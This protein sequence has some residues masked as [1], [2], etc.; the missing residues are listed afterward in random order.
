MFDSTRFSLRFAFRFA[1]RVSMV[2]ALVFCSGFINGAV[3]ADDAAEEQIRVLIID[4]QNNHND[5]PKI[6]A[7]LKQ[8]LEDNGK[9]TVD[10]ERTRFTFKGDK[11]LKEF[12]LDDGKEYKSGKRAKT[13][14]EFKPDFSKYDVVVSNFGHGAADWPAE[15]QS[16]FTK[17][18]REGGGLVSIHAADNSFPGWKEYNEMIGLGGW[19][20]RDENSGPY[21]YYNEDG[22]V[23][24]D[25]SKG[26]GG[27]H[28][29]QH[30]FSL[31][32]RDAEHPITKGLPKEFL[33]AKDELYE[34]L[35]GPALNL[36]ILATAFAAKKYKG[37]GRHEP[38]L[39]SIEFGEGRIFHST[40]GHATYS[41]E[42]VAFITTFLRGTQWA[43]TGEVTIE[44]PDDFPSA[45]KS[46]SR[47]FKLLSTGETA[48]EKPVLKEKPMKLKEKHLKMEQKQLK[49][50][51]KFEKAGS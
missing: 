39:M 22:E 20:N 24:R 17:F 2:V 38:T 45:D 1:F 29:P 51:K 12:S 6:T 11:W 13:D 31:V 27:N 47:E 23:V 16:A 35:R 3:M 43:A 33:H 44:V 30:E 10:V 14:P 7:M 34:K 26:R 4:G 40:L 46:S 36:N 42:C 19:G 15:T 25:Q 41:C 5:W 37:S 21:V 8:Y 9:F 28:G 49:M 32:V 50:E 18:I 48:S